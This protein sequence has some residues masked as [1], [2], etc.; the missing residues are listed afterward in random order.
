M[1]E[2]N[3]FWYPLAAQIL[4]PQ[5]LL[6]IIFFVTWAITGLKD[7]NDNIIIKNWVEFFSAYEL[8]AANITL[9]VKYDDPLPLGQISAGLFLLTSSTI[10][11]IL[12]WGYQAWKNTR[13]TQRQR[14]HLSQSSCRCLPILGSLRIDCCN[15]TDSEQRMD[16]WKWLGIGTQH[17]L[18]LVH[19]LLPL[20]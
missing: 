17:C 13:N 18:G 2:I 6:V 12:L 19:S 5:A 3:Q 10:L 8:L 11:Q 20:P 15:C 14:Y 4:F 7:E 1:T 9:F 16:G